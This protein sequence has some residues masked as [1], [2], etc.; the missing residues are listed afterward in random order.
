MCVCIY[1]FYT[2]LCFASSIIPSTILSKI[3]KFCHYEYYYYKY[4]YK[5]IH[6]V[7]SLISITHMAVSLEMN[8]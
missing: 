1:T 5:Y 4:S 8:I 3:F 2:P 7:T 6:N